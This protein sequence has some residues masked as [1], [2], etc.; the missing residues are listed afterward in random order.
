V[1][2]LS[3]VIVCEVHYLLRCSGTFHRSVGKREDGVALL[4]VLQSFPCFLQSLDGIVGANL[5]M[6]KRLRQTFDLNIW[7]KKCLD[8]N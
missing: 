8:C 3:E 7:K 5:W 4:E 2:D 6:V 1:D